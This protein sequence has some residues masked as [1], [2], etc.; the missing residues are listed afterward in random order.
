MHLTGAVTLLDADDVGKLRDI[1]RHMVGSRLTDRKKW[2]LV[3][4]QGLN[5]IQITERLTVTEGRKIS[6]KSVSKTLRA[7]QDDFLLQ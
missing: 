2:I 1:A 3:L 4:K 6:A 7:V 5:Q